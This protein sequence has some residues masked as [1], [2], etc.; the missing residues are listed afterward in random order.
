MFGLNLV[1]D[2]QVKFGDG[3][4]CFDQGW[5]ARFDRRDRDG[6]RFG[7][8]VPPNR[9]EACDCSGRRNPLKVLCVDLFRPSS[10]VA[11]SLIT[12]SEPRKPRALGDA[13]VRLH[14]DSRTPTDRRAVANASPTNFAGSG[15]YRY[16][17]RVSASCLRQSQ[18]GR[19]G[20][21]AAQIALILEALG[22]C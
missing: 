11:H 14:F 4:A 16:V 17:R 2:H 5:Y 13:R 7:E 6:L 20:L 18:V 21:L 3:L 15:R 9:H 10:V 22:G 1:R 8:P 12:R 19:F